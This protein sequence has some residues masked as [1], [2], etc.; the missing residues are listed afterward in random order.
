MLPH[1]KCFPNLMLKPDRDLVNY[2]VK[3]IQ[4][5]ASSI[6]LPH[7]KGHQG[8]IVAYTEL[9]LD[10]QPNCDSD[11]KAVY[12]QSIYESYHPHVPQITTN[13]AQLHISGKTINTGYRTAISEA[14]TTPALRAQISEC[15]DWSPAVLA[16]FHKEAHSQALSHMVARHSQLIKL[17]HDLVPTAAITHRYHHIHPAL[18][19]I[20]TS[21]HPKILITSSAATTQ[22]KIPGG[23]PCT[24]LFRK[25]VIKTSLFHF[26]LISL[27]AALMHGSMAYSL[28]RPDTHEN[29]TN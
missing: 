4:S 28:I 15:N 22:T 14:I 19:I 25:L 16:T 24:P 18:C 27:S 7:V 1:I 20:C 6:I 11:Y 10:A 8:N 3:T 2:I 23:T 17:C 21:T 26:L 5:M 9:P 12:H 29:T 13:K